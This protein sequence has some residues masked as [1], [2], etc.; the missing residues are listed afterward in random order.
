[1]SQAGPRLGPLSTFAGEGPCRVGHQTTRRHGRDH[2]PRHRRER[3]RHLAALELLKHLH[4]A[5]AEDGRNQLPK[6]LKPRRKAPRLLTLISQPARTVRSRH[7]SRLLRIH[8]LHRLGR[9]ASH[10]LRSAASVQ[11]R[12]STTE[13]FE[14]SPTACRET[15]TALLR[16]LLPLSPTP[17]R[18]DKRFTRERRGYFRAVCFHCARLSA[19]IFVDLV[20]AWLICANSATSRWTRWPSFCR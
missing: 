12:R 10:R 20:A 16:P 17:Y 6:G 1:M 2:V 7:R 4:C 11:I 9:G 8:A 15:V 19:M 3:R 13:F 18:S 5:W 14:T